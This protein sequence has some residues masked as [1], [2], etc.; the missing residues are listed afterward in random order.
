[1]FKTAVGHS[2]DPDSLSAIEEVLQQCVSSLG[3]DIPKAGI[4]FSAIDFEH[5]L[6][7]QQ[8]H[9]AFP[10][11]E[12]IGGTTDGE[13]SSVLEFQQD[14]ITLMLFCSDEVEINAGIGRKVSGDPIAVTKQAVQQAKA[15]TTETPR[16]CLTHPES[17][18][19][20]G[21]SI[22]DGLKLAL[23]QNVPIFG[24]LA[25]DQSRYQNTY[26]FFQ[27]E[28]LSDSVPILLFSGTIL[29]SHGVASGW[30]PI[31]QI[32]QVTKVDKNILYEIDGK[33]AL[34][35]YH[36]YLGLL[37]PSIEY[38]LAVFDQNRD[39]FYIR[40]PIAYNQK[41]GSI[42]FFADIPDRAVI[43][44]AEACYEDILAASKASFM[45][46]LN[47]YPGAEPSAVLFFSCV[48][49]RQILGTRTQEEY[50]NT[51]L[52]LTYHLPGCGF[53]SYGEIAPI[54][55]MSQTQFHNETFVTLILGTR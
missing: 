50:Q 46:A 15:K 13:I 51:K 21:V 2:N 7:L 30:H 12:L 47:N 14:S 11:I 25:G 8:I 53:Y 28:V 45:N 27:T 9:Q 32:S 6:I 10:G 16:L 4:L 49:R 18:T 22:L 5:A 37:P 1:M 38:P 39:N 23:G 43:Q 20:S 24:G 33:P 3:G 41:S 35:F 52:C 34:D 54:N 42:T 26:Q 44:I 19:I 36:H 48:A 17:L 31:G 40:A 55:G 29:F